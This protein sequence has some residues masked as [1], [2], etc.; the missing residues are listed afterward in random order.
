MKR[1]Y[2]IKWIQKEAKK[3]DPDTYVVEHKFL[4]NSQFNEDGE[5]L[6]GYYEEHQVNHARRLKRCYDIGGFPLMEKYFNHY[7]LKL[8]RNE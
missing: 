6:I 4:K 3:L 5:P 8:E 1:K 2:V 7:G